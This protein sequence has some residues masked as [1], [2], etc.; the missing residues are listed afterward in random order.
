MIPIKWTAP[1]AIEEKKYSTASDV[2]SY[3]C[4]LYEIWSLG[5]KPYDQFSNIEV[6]FAHRAKSLFNSI[7]F[8]YIVLQAIR[9]VKKGKR[10]SPPPGCP[11][12]IYGLMIQC[13]YAMTSSCLCMIS[14][15]DYNTCCR[16]PTRSERPNF[17]SIHLRLLENEQD[18]LSIPQEALDTHQLA[19]VLGSP[20][21]AGE[22]MYEDLQTKYIEV[23]YYAII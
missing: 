14:D 22:R 6:N 4:L 9:F 16:N 5:H 7:V 11:E 3:G 8:V 17:R 2:W 23:E 21:K 13:W 12:A 20:L 18:V 15:N 10:L 19:G 1:E